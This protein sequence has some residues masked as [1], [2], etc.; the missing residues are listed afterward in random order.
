MA[1]SEFD[2]SEVMELAA[3]FESAPAALPKYLRKSLEVTSRKVKN[4]A[5]E[6][7]KRREMVAQA[8]PAI[9]YELG[10]SSGTVST[11]SSDI[12]YRKGFGAG[13]LGNL[14]EF[15]APRAREVILVKNKH[16]VYWLAKPDAPIRSLAPGMELQ[17]SLHENEDDFEK[18]VLAAIDDSLREVG[19]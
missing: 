12:G 3:N 8:A 14:V 9:D 15:G 10:G 16:G 6:K 7:V 19:L 1:A 11:M 17:R 13:A 2:F 5:Q 18:G 4:G